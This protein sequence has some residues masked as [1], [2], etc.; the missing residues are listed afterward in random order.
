MRYGYLT[1]LA[2]AHPS[3]SGRTMWLC[4]CDC[5][6]I[7]IIRTGDLTSGKTVSCGCYHLKAITI[8]G[9][10]KRNNRHPLYVIWNGMISRCNNTKAK[11]YHNYGARGISVCEEWQDV[12]NFIRDMSASWK[13]GLQLDRIDTNGNY[14]PEN[15][16]WVTLR[17]NINNRRNTVY[18][19]GLPVTVL[20]EMCGIK[21]DTLRQR[22][23]CGW[24]DDELLKPIA[25][26][27]K[28][29]EV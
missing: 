4:Q 15:C 20:S 3:K 28:R 6:N 2:K 22:I 29:E 27:K 14:C 25:S 7:K 21:P 9:M 23:R 18:A 11:D 16:R 13:P 8:H 5:G 12:S 1:V 19:L 10:S 17:E 26:T 24:S